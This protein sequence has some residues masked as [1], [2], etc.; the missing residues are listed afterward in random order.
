MRLNSVHASRLSSL[1]PLESR[2]APAAVLPTISADGH[3]ATWTDVDGDKVT[4]VITK[5]TLEADGSNF[6]L[7]SGPN[8]GAILQK[9]DLSATEFKGTAV[10][11]TAVR[12][13]IAGGNNAVDVGFLDA[14]D[15]A[16]GAVKI[17]G[18]LA[19]IVAGLPS[20]TAKLPKAVSSLSVFS[21]GQYGAM[22]LDASELGLLTSEIT[23]KMG[24][25]KVRGSVTGISFSVVGGTFAGIDSLSIGGSLVGTAE[26]QSGS[27]TTTGPIKSVSIKGSILGGEGQQ[28]G[29]IEA[30]GKIGTVS[31]AGSIIGGHSPTESNDRSGFLRSDT[32]FGTITIKG[33]VSGGTQQSSGVIS[34]SGNVAS[35]TVTGSVQGG[36]AGTLNGAIDIGGA[37]GVLRIGGDIAGGDAEQSGYVKIGGNATAVSLGGSVKGGS[38]F[39][40]GVLAFGTDALDTVALLTL[41]RDIRGG[42]G[43]NSG[44][45]QSTGPILSATVKGSILGGSGDSSG[46]IRSEG[47]IK[48][49]TVSGSL[50][51]GDLA[52]DATQ[53]L[54][55]SGYVEAARIS[56]FT[57]GGSVITGTN[58]NTT[59]DLVN[60]AAIRSAN[61]IGTLTIKGSIEGN[62]DALALITARGQAVL[63]QNAL[64]DVAINKLTVGGRVSYANILAGYDLT[65]DITAADANPNAQIVSVTV[66]N[67]WIASNLLSGVQLRS[68]IG[69]G[70]DALASGVDNPDIDAKI[71]TILIK[72]SIAGTATSGDHYGFV[73]QWITIFQS[74]SPTLQLTSPGFLLL[75]TN[76]GNDNSPSD[77]KYN[78]SSSEDTRIFEVALT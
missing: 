48:L 72:G 59:F 40:S 16:L 34:T 49:L 60:S 27:F 9:L 52:V 53:D 42:S 8:Q 70:N 17:N 63:V 21:L 24:A 5:G 14:H 68:N 78:L 13:K 26:S 71:G 47:A 28:S 37:V 12:D 61:D 38:V 1:E 50:I 64:T 22:N 7:E 6:D 36:K 73:A 66:A 56:T 19:K 55:E 74:G 2:I 43:E 46:V 41:G 33:N 15:N 54:L 67:D 20:P 30:D 10:S 18:D 29:T 25:V 69:D 57:L 11:I 23:G 44:V 35:L 45:V 75:N 39:N 65:D 51:G 76:G 32:G 31:I 77:P 3:R 4:L 62:A 58:Y